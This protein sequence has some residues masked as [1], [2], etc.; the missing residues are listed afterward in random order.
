MMTSRIHLSVCLTNGVVVVTATFRL[1]AASL[2]Q[3]NV[4]LMLSSS[5]TTPFVRQTDTPTN[6]NTYHHSDFLLTRITPCDL[7]VGTVEVIGFDGFSD[8]VARISRVVIF[9]SVTLQNVGT[10]WKKKSNRINRCDVIV[11]NVP[12][13][14]PCSWKRGRKLLESAPLCHRNNRLPS[15]RLISVKLFLP[16]ILPQCIYLPQSAETLVG[17]ATWKGK[18]NVCDRA[19][20]REALGRHFTALDPNVIPLF[21][22]FYSPFKALFQPVGKAQYYVW[23]VRCV[24]RS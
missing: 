15:H 20:A 18:G 4:D 7:D 17:T 11:Q 1:R 19:Q 8:F 6:M 22:H 14:L 5:S 24:L 10:A 16:E 23:I 21:F 2:H 9:I 3:A 13:S 12:E